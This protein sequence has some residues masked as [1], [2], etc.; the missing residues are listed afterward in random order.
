[1]RAAGLSLAGLLL[2]TTASAQPTPATQGRV[3]PQA[4]PPQAHAYAQPAAPGL[5]PPPP[6]PATL[7]ASGGAPVTEVRI[8]AGTATRA[9][10][11][12]PSWRPPADAGQA[13]TLDHQP[14]E[15]LDAAWVRRQFARNGVPGADVGRALAVIQLVN[16]AVLSA[17]YINSGVVVRPS[18]A[19]GV[20]AVELIYGG[21]AEGPDGPAIS[22]A[23]TAGSAGGLDARYVRDRM[24]SA[25]RRPLNALELERD[26][27]L[28]A[29]DPALRTL[30]AD[31]RPGAR[32]GEAALRLSVLPQD[33]FDLY[34]TAANDRSPSVGGEH[35]AVGG[36]VR[37][38]I[39]PGDVFSLNAGLTDG[40]E[41]VGVG[42]AFPFVSPRTSISLRASYNEA[43]VVDRLLAPLEITAKDKAFEAG[44]TRRLFEAPL[45]PGD[46]PGRWSS[47][48]T[49]S[50]GLGFA[51]RKAESRLLGERFSFAPGAVDGRAEY[52]AL[53][54][55]ADYVV[56][57]VDQVF[58][59]SLVGT[60]GL[61]GTKSD[62]PG[63]PV[64]EMD[65]HAVLAQLN[66]ARRL[67][68]GVELRA[69]L[70]GQWADS[71]LYAGERLSAGGESTVRGYRE[72]LLLADKG[73]IGSVELARGFN[74]SGRQGAGRR[75][76][77]GL[78]TAS[79][80]ADGAYM[81][82]VAGPQGPREIYGAGA[83]LA[84]TPADWLFARL[85]LARDLKTVEAPGERDLQDRGVA[86]RV[87]LRPLLIWR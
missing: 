84:W 67:P 22:V 82:N 56:R 72:N 76:D 74:L 54:L 73:L 33:R 44:V 81:R 23:W 87:T 16:R 43:A 45:M 10:A 70:Y 48:Q 6:A 21:L 7:A 51:W 2:A 19:E 25:L 79:V 20:L 69:R 40:V 58:A 77:W 64:P 37:N 1:M 8:A 26:F 39:G 85:T 68:H 55:S 78:F 29:E 35:L 9:A 4:A 31:L 71:V 13:L 46:R 65:F 18:P 62:A 14:G 38:L 11:P 61:D 59:A 63:L 75:F 3:G 53:R 27:R 83:A 12:P 80:F 41:D 15:A 52:R 47:A 66:Y 17:G 50:L 86:F 32:P 57:N 24:P 36:S 30:N 49:L 5:A 60:R 42:Y 34:V 28:L